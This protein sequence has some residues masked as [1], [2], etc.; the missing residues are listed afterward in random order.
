MAFQHFL[1]EQLDE[2]CVF[3]TSCK[4]IIC[5]LPLYLLTMYSP[6]TKTFSLDSAANFFIFLHHYTRETTQLFPVIPTTTTTMI[7]AAFTPTL[8]TSLSLP[9]NATLPLHP[10]L[11]YNTVAWESYIGFLVFGIIA[12]VLWTGVVGTLFAKIYL[13]AWR[14]DKTIEGKEEKQRDLEAAYVRLTEPEKVAR[15][16]RERVE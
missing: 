16:A 9:I 4:N 10:S 8:N 14:V 6:S 1:P 7:M 13:E 12:F 11:N 3:Y 2:H 5:V 15:V